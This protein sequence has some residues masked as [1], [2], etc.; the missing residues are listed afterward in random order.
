[1]ESGSLSF[2]GGSD[3]AAADESKRARREVENAPRAGRGRR[4]AASDGAAACLVAT[5]TA[6][7]ACRRRRVDANMGIPG[8]HRCLPF[9]EGTAI[10]RRLIVS[11]TEGS[12][13]P[14][15]RT[16][17]FSLSIVF[18]NTSS[19]RLTAVHLRKKFKQKDSSYIATYDGI[20]RVP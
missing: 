8:R 12:E 16:I 3:R 10:K 1:M 6:V 11:I 2:G 15:W 18:M 13:V 14:I 17:A 7:R 4:A 20:D 5:A 19:S 9:W